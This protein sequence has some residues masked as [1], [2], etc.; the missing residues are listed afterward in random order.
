MN[1]EG[2]GEREEDARL[3][4]KIRGIPY[5]GGLRRD[6]ARFLGS[7]AE[8]RQWL[9]VSAEGSDNGLIITYVASLRLDTA[10]P[11]RRKLRVCPVFRYRPAVGRFGGCGPECHGASKTSQEGRVENQPF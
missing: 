8:N 2:R 6:F 1:H 5:D 4:H 7:A 3:T 11:Y 10:I 9:G